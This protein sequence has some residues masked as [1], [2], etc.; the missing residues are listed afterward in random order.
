[1]WPHGDQLACPLHQL[2]VACSCQGNSRKP[3]PFPFVPSWPRGPRRP[4]PGHAWYRPGWVWLQGTLEHRPPPPFPYKSPLLPWRWVGGSGENKAELKS[5]ARRDPA[6]SRH[7]EQS[8][9]LDLLGR[10]FPVKQE[11]RLAVTGRCTRAVPPPGAGPTGWG[12]RITAP[13]LVEEVR[14]SFPL[15]GNLSPGCKMGSWTVK[16]PCPRG[17]VHPR[18]QGVAEGTGQERSVLPTPRCLWPP[19]FRR[20]GDV[21]D[22]AGGGSR[23]GE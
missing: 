3:R 9:P 10:I 15:I 19:G 23:R 2:Q 20:W 13:V 21:R 12:T 7:C 22:H 1:M 18:G 16:R 8:R 17:S 11:P 14:P 5:L 4:A 6:S